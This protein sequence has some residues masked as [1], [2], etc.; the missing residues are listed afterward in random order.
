M[1]ASIPPVP[2]V[3][4]ALP[5]EVNTG[6]LMA[7]AGAAP[8]YQAAAAW[9]ALAIALETQAEELSASLASLAGSWQGGASEQAIQ[10][11]T[12]MIV[13]LHTAALQAQK[14]AMQAIAQANSYLLAMAVT[15]PLVEIE[16][17]HV[18]HAVLEATNF[19]GVN[20]VPIGVNEFDYFVRMWTQA[21][22]AMHGYQ[23]ETAANIMFEPIPPLKPIVMPGV[24][25]AALGFASGKIAATLPGS[26]MRE[27]AFAQVAA[28]ASIESAA[29]HVGRAA[30]NSNA[31]MVSAQTQAR[32]GEN[33]AQQAQGEPEQL[34]QGA[35]QG[36]QMGMQ[37]AS[38]VGSM[39]AQAPQ[40][41][42]QTVTQPM[43][44][45]LAPMQQ[46]S[47]M[48]GQ[49]GG[50]LNKGAQF[51]LMGAS[52]FSNHPL[53]GG[54]GAGAGAGL[55]RAASLPGAGGTLASTPLMSGLLGQPAGAAAP[56]GAAAG[57]AGS[58]LAPVGNGAG[59]GPMGG[60]GQGAK[61]G[62]NRQ[63]LAAPSALAHDL[64]EDEDEDDDW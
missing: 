38:Q 53:A 4:G 5:P 9:E 10:A 27:L 14:R 37:V 49:L 25:E 56:V 3:Y 57:G 15:P 41:M 63:G 13:W 26:A 51:G 36:A 54:T 60:M 32:K 59:G 34:M 47:S 23:A 58:G 1:V 18:T 21:A 44:Q 30:A 42:M 33:T 2:F 46:V 62:T 8:M 24:G 39:L 52:P 48:F 6:R 19:L 12:P 28:Q 22:V 45:I 16:A 50:G 64:G 17:N 29:L 31:A 40:Q 43:Q 20:T 61:R 7:G 55:V 35:Q 11:T